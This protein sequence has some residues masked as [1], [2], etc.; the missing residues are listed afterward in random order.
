[1]GSFVI[2]EP[3]PH[4]WGAKP[5]VNEL[6]AAVADPAD[7]AKRFQDGRLEMAGVPPSAAAQ[8]AGDAA[9]AGQL[10]KTPRLTE[11]WIDFN[12]SRAPFDNP[13]V[14]QA[15]AQ[16]IDRAAYIKDAWAGEAR[17][18]T[19]L[20]PE[21]MPA[22]P[23]KPASNDVFDAGAARGL[24]GASGEPASQFD[25]L[26]LLV[27]DQPFDKAAAGEISDQ[28]KSNLGITVS[29]QP[30][31]PVQ[32][33]S[34]LQHGDFQLAGPVG[35]TADYPDPQDWFDLFRTYDGRDY[36]HWRNQRYDL[37][38]QLGDETQDQTK[39]LQAYNQAQ[40]VLLAELP[41]VPLDQVEEW[42]LVKPNVHGLAPSPYDAAGFAGNL[43]AAKISVTPA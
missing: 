34:R 24:L 41:F 25:G 39:R 2:L 36:P 16:A 15:F 5:R 10:V 28:L 33:A 7:A 38:V 26:Q 35:W 17:I 20:I 23:A 14:R 31:E 30:V 11:H 29:V 19:G 13:K 8:V 1:M 18:A 27:P 4:Y 37:L 21:G 43:A 32:Y 40:Q 12:T 22:H 3:N 9:L 6:V 42:V